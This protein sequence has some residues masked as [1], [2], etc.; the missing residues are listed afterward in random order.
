MPGNRLRNLSIQFFIM[1]NF[2]IEDNRKNLVLAALNAM[3]TKRQAA[4]AL[5][6]T[7]GTLRRF[8]HNYNIA[9]IDDVYQFVD[10]KK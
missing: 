1:Q 4:A 10:T 5:G 6:V 2:N 8:I 9:K 7:K 3:P